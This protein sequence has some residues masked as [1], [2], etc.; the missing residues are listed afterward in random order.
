ML[1]V[2]TFARLRAYG[3]L[4][5]FGVVITI[6]LLAFGQGFAAH[7]F[8]DPTG[9]V[10]AEPTPSLGTAWWWLMR[11]E[12]LE[13]EAAVHGHN[14]GRAFLSWRQAVAMADET[15]QREQFALTQHLALAGSLLRQDQR[16]RE[17]QLIASAAES[18]I[19]AAMAVLS[20]VAWRARSERRKA[21]RVG[22]LLAA[23]A[24]VAVEQRRRRQELLRESSSRS[25]ALQV[26]AAKVE[27]LDLARA[28]AVAATV[29]AE[30]G[31]RSAQ[32]D[33]LEVERRRSAVAR[34]VAR[35]AGSLD[36]A[37]ALALPPPVPAGREDHKREI[38]LERRWCHSLL[39]LAE[40]AARMSRTIPRRR[41]GSTSDA[42]PWLLQLSGI[43][44]LAPIA[45]RV[46]P[47]HV[48]PAGRT[49]S[50][51]WIVATTTQAVSSPAAGR[52]VFAEPFRG[53]GQLLIIDRGKGY[54]VLLS[55]LTQLDVDRGASV[56]A[57]QAIG[58]IVAA[59][60][61]STRLHVELR[62]RGV[63]VD[64]G[65]WQVA[66]EGKVRS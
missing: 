8:D 21:P 57:G 23:V 51:F 45:G 44:L 46:Q 64:P 39:R 5:S 26:A 37:E 1:A 50:G 20:R 32:L 63:P 56:V 55:G 28:T 59:R 43:S 60:K 24:G 41:L 15:G 12:E 11:Q 6:W 53:F 35:L 47:V 34:Q 42:S 27:L 17:L 25:L 4:P 22:P 9:A 61:R 10:A 7:A 40:E 33:W 66:R 52:V 62:H 31:V 16:Q 48:S 18:R 30:A 29:T 65:S 13:R 49:A 2:W 14:T 38:G 58:E 36:S 3:R 54:H 19:T